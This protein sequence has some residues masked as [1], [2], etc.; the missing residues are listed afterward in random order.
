MTTLGQSAQTVSRS[1]PATFALR[2]QHWASSFKDRPLV[3]LVVGLRLLS[4]EELDSCRIDAGKAAL[5]ATPD[6]REQAYQTKLLNS[7]VSRAICMPED[8]SQSHDFFPCP[9]DQLP[10]V[11]RPETVVAMFDVLER[12]Q[13]ES[14]P[15]ELPATNGDIV[16][17]VQLMVDGALEDLEAINPTRAYRIR[18]LLSFIKSELES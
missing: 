15:L 5:A 14:S 12:T 6:D 9:D 18:R 2:P 8:S 4:A 7:A 11:L 3:D 13:I 16:D 17:L 1:A 10:I